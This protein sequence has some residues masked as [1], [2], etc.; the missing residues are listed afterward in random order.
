[1]KYTLDFG[2]LLSNGYPTLILGGLATTLK[3][4]L[5]AWLMAFTLGS[6]L[7]V[8]RMLNLRP[9]NWLIAV[10]VAFHRNVPM[11]VHILLWYFGVASIVPPA[12]NDA[13]NIIG[14]EFFYATIAIGLVTAA[15]VGEDLR[16]AIRAIPRGQM[17]AA[18]SLGLGYLQ[19]MRKVILPQAFKIS[20]PPLTNQTLLLFKNTS[21]AMAIG[22]I[23]LTGAGREIESATFKTFEIYF[24]VTVLYLAISLLLMLAGAYLSKRVAYVAKAR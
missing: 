16:S 9:L 3:M 15:Y 4:T 11:L 8:L 24:V 2:A 23:E 6:L 12:L 17:E 18:R 7:A 14:G 1:M 21:L 19:A 13:I 10:Y 22:L 20:I 5:L